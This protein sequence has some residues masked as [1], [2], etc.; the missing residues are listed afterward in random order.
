M[1]FVI[2]QLYISQFIC[3]LNLQLSLNFDF[4]FHNFNFSLTNV[5]ILY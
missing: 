4:V 1:L 3:F 5:T 2:L